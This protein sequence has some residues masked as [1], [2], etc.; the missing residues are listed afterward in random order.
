MN[1]EPGVFTDNLPDYSMIIGGKRSDLMS[2]VRIFSK[3]NKNHKQVF[4][5]KLEHFPLY[6]MLFYLHYLM[7]RYMN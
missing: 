2:D 3:G 7:V 5:Q 1:I 6:Q 4:T